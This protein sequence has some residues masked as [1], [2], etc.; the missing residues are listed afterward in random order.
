MDKL[1][2]N[3]LPLETL[4]GQRVFVRLDVDTEPS[5]AGN[6]FDEN[7]LHASLPTSEPRATSDRQQR[8]WR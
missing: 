8:G 4:R 2:I 6:L 5:P 3:Q 1:V 7:K